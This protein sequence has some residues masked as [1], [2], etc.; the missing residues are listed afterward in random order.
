M[1]VYNTQMFPNQLLIG[2]PLP[3]Y[4][5]FKTI[6]LEKKLEAEHETMEQKE[7]ELTEVLQRANLDPSL[8]GRV[9]LFMYCH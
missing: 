1:T 4:L 8:L 6:L 3:H 7:A 5:R 9:C 2:C